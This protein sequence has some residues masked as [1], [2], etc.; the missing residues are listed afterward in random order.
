MRESGK[1]KFIEFSLNFID[2]DQFY[3]TALFELATGGEQ[4]FSLNEFLFKGND[5]V[6]SIVNL[7][8]EQDTTLIYTT[9]NWVITDCEIKYDS[10]GNK[11]EITTLK[12]LF[13]LYRRPDDSSQTDVLQRQFETLQFIKREKDNTYLIISQIFEGTRFSL[14]NA[15]EREDTTFSTFD[16]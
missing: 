16:C 4:W 11:I 13:T 5:E 6:D 1:K 9:P 8:L 14:D 10:Y 3:E 15:K 7:L 2:D 12:S